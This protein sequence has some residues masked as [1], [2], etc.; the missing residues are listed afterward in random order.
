[1][2]GNF[3]LPPVLEAPCYDRA[4]RGPAAN[5]GLLAR[6]SF[7]DDSLLT[8]IARQGPG[9]ERLRGVLTRLRTYSL[10]EEDGGWPTS[11]QI[12]KIHPEPRE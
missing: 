2:G 1:M 3:Q 11:L 6:D 5:R 12:D 10:T 7:G 9:D 4:P 8:E